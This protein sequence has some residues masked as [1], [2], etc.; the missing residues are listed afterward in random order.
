M[1]DRRFSRLPRGLTLHQAVVAMTPRRVL[2]AEDNG[3]LRQ[4]LGAMLQR[5][6][7]EVIE[8]ED[9]DQLIE[10]LG[11]ALANDGAEPPDVIISDIRMPG[12]SGLDML[13]GLRRA[14]V[15]T[16]VILITG[17]GDDETHTEARRLGAAAV[18]NKPFELD[19]LR[20]AVLN[21]TKA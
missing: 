18:F 2:I 5:D 8:V 20:T 21:L 1:R 13:A 14:E 12:F 6:G 15:E 9:G 10:Y 19:D 16:P 17:F 3:D 7:Y 11:L 4:M